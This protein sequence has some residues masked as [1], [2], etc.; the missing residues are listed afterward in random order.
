MAIPNDGIAERPKHHR[1]RLWE[2]SSHRRIR[3]A[4]EFRPSR[5]RRIFGINAA[6]WQ[7]RR[8]VICPEFPA[9]SADVSY[10]ISSDGLRE[11]YFSKPTPGSPNIHEPEVD[12]SRQVVINEIMYHPSS[13]NSAEEY[14]EIL[15][16][17]DTEI[18]LRNWRL[19]GGV[20]FDFP[21]MLIPAGGYLV[22]ASDVDAFR[23]KYGDAVDVV[24]PWTGQLSNSSD[25]LNLRDGS[26]LRVD[27]VTY[28][29]EGDWAVRQRG[30]DDRGSQGWIWSDLHDGGGRSLELIDT[31]MPNEYGQNWS[32]SSVDQGT[33]GERNSVASDDAAPIIA[34]VHHAPII[35]DSNDSVTVSARVFDHTITFVA[36]N[37]RLDGEAE[38]RQVTMLDNGGAGD[39][40][41]NDGVYSAT[42]PAQPN[43]TIVEFYVSASD[44]QHT[45]T[46]PSETLAS[47]QAT[48]GLYQVLDSHADQP[49]THG[50]AAVYF[51][52]MTAAERTE[53]TNINRRSD[54]QMHA[55]FISADGEG[56]K[57]RYNAGVRI[58]GS[59]SRNANPPNNRINIPSD[60]PVER[61]DRDQSERN[62]DTQPSCRKCDISCIRIAC[63]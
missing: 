13:E 22:I 53:F 5:R 55:T 31:A 23:A 40:F 62:L 10:G 36:L 8:V 46:W 34:D 57:V 38:F 7:Y 37:W 27:T 47:G 52:V 12:P 9:Q 45:Q 18:S 54:A 30:P 35:P 60:R 42:I 26:N 29:D 2:R 25:R 41:A 58:R 39:A 28:A 1:F 43:L 44:G 32:A 61:K 16:T 59:G 51:E 4:Y 19:S 56:I 6:G 11:G 20:D 15:N 50:D 24:G 63:G 48:N 17:S 21:T 33:P 49:W 14:I 3:T